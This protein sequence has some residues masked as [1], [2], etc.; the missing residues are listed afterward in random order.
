M[1]SLKKN[2]GATAMQ[3]GAAMLVLGTVLLMLGAN[4]S[5]H[6][7]NAWSLAAASTLL[8]AGMLLPLVLMGAAGCMPVARLSVVGALIAAGVFVLAYQSYPATVWITLPSGGLGVSNPGVVWITLPAAGMG[9]LWSL[10]LLRLALQVQSQSAKARMLALAA[11]LTATLGI[12]LV[13]QSDLSRIT[14]ITAAAC[15]A[16]WIGVQILM[17]IPLLYRELCARPVAMAGR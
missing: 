13:V 9:I 10:W 15:F 2:W 3:S 8:C 4:M 1:Q 12:L 5:A 7:A 16:F 17:S 6:G 11:A 14:A